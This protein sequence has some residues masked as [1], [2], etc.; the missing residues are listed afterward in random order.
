MGALDGKVVVFTGAGAGIGRAVVARYITEGAKVVAVDIS[1]K[2]L[3]L[4]QEHG[5]AVIPVQADITTTGRQRDGVRRRPRYGAG[6]T[7]SSAM[8]GSPTPWSPSRRSRAR[9]SA[10]PSTNSSQ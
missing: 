5:D 8:L 6:S 1:P 2:V 7:S 10:K 4:T 3:E 9:H